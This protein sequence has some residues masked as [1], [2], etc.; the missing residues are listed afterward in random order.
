VNKRLILACAAAALGTA[1]AAQTAPKSITRTDYLKGVDSHFNAA[2]TNHD[3][4][5]SKAELVVQQQRELDQAKARLNQ[6]LQAKFNQLDTNKDG[7]LT[8]QEFLGAAPPLRVGENADQLM[9]RLDTNHDGKMSA[10]EFRAPE[11][12]KF[13]KV[14]ANRDGTVTPQEAQAARGK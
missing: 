5:V 7:K 9:Q 4:F 11:L 1:A 8:L 2:D 10:E 3:G 13:N 12:A 6:Q 14:D